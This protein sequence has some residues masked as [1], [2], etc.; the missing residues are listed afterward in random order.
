MTDQEKL[1]VA[2]G[3]LE[4]LEPYARRCVEACEENGDGYTRRW[5]VAWQ[6]SLMVIRALGQIRGELPVEQIERKAQ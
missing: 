6:Q 2:M 5:F 3:A 4:A 1:A